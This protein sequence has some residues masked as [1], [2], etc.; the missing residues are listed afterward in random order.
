MATVGTRIYT[1]LFGKRVGEDRF[2]NVYYTEKKAPAGRRA[3]RWVIYK[4]LDEG[5]KVPAEWHSW[6]HYTTEA[7]LSEK[8]EDRYEWQK[9]HQP[10]LTGT[11]YA[12]RP[13]GHDYEGG[14]RAK[15]TGDYQAWSPEG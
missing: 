6:L 10:N 5:S 11:K 13:Q 3:K 4:G 14:K 8:P 15:A 1:S 2:G 9:D 12:Y 7:P